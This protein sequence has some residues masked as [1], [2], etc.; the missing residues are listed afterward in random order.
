MTA[1]V[2]MVLNRFTYSL[3]SLIKW[4]IEFIFKLFNLVT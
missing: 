1:I 4:E 2:I 3:I